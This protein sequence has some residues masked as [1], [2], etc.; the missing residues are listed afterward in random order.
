LAYLEEGNSGYLATTRNND[1]QTFSIFSKFASI[2]NTA[3]P[4]GVLCVIEGGLV[5]RAFGV[6][7][8]WHLL[9]FPKVTAVRI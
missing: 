5:V 3:R 1:A 6:K 4:V 8:V 7:T 2:S 9:Y